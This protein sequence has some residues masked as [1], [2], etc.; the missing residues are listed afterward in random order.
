MAITYTWKPVG[1][2]KRRM[3]PAYWHP[4]YEFIEKMQRTFPN[5]VSLGDI[6][7]KVT[8]GHVGRSAYTSD[9][10]TCIGVRDILST[11]VDFS[12]CRFI[13]ENGPI[14]YPRCRVQV[15]DVLTIRSGIG[16]LGRTVALTSLGGRKACVSGDV[17]L[18]RI[19]RANPH[20]IA[21]F[22]MTPYGQ[23]QLKRSSSG[24]SRQVHINIGP[25]KAIRIPLLPAHMQEHVETRYVQM[26]GFHS[27][28]MEAKAAGN[29]TEYKEKLAYA[30]QLLDD[31]I[32]YVE[33]VI[34]AGPQDAKVE[35]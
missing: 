31:L 35:N 29:E 18:L 23:Q 33:N 21:S 34:K 7:E 9:G 1:E 27:A 2:I 5:T 30:E 24:S 10:I 13:E 15:G 12:T 14:D 17:Y 3:D 8:L 20:Y 6:L 19:R 22:L 4:E 32:A 26:A 25:L 16:S 28:A 11:G